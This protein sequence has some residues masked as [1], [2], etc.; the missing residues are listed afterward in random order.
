VRH[1]YEDGEAGAAWMLG[2]PKEYKQRALLCAKRARTSQSPEVRQKF[3]DLAQTWLLFAVQLEEQRAL[4]DHWGGH[5]RASR[6][7]K[8]ERRPEADAPMLD[9]QAGIELGENGSLTPRPKGKAR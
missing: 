2:D 7:L 1:H 3:A 8:R 9:A 6:A 4:I 5:P